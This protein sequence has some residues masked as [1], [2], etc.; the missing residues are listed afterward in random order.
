M[1]NTQHL[2]TP[3]RIRRS[4][5]TCPEAPVPLH[6]AV[7]LTENSPFLLFDDQ[8]TIITTPIK[9]P[10][11]DDAPYAPRKMPPLRTPLRPVKNVVCPPR[12]TKKME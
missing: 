9:F 7:Q 10:A 2:T 11:S 8:E 12:P 3:P 5:V 1:S 6:R 4:S